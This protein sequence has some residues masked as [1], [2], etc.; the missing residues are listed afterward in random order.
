MV[1]HIIRISNHT[2][3]VSHVEMI[4]LSQANSGELVWFLL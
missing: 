4:D 1:K 2:K 3:K